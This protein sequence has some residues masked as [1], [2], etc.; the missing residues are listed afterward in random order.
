MK[1]LVT[2]VA[3]FIGADLTSRLLAAGHEVVGVDNFNDY[4]APEL[5]RDRSCQG[6][7]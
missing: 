2:G 4:Y 5:K 6:D 1:V 3:G 7:W